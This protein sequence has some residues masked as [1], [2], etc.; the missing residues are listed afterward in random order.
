MDRVLA[1]RFRE[2]VRTAAGAGKP[3]PARSV[4]LQKNP[5][6]V[7]GIAGSSAPPSAALRRRHLATR[8]DRTRH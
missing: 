1:V 4:A 6:A 7:A 2:T 5:R 3:V 8:S